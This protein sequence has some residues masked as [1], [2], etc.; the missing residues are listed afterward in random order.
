MC[1]RYQHP[2]DDL[3]KLVALEAVGY[4]RLYC[5][6]IPHPIQVIRGGTNQRPLTPGQSQQS[7]QESLAAANPALAFTGMPGELCFD[8][9]FL[10]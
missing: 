9:F 4:F 7:Q 2:G 8:L 3:N 10:F 1:A 5:N 6:S